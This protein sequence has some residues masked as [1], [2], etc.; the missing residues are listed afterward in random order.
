MH[1]T[2]PPEGTKRPALPFADQPYVLLILTMLFWAGNTLLGRA[3]AG[4]IPPVALAQM[5]WTLAFLILLP[6]ALPHL[7]RDLPDMLRSWKIL[8]ILGISGITLYNTFLYIG[9]QTTSAVNAAMLI[10][11]FPIIVALMGFA[12]F[13]D[14][15]TP[16]QVAGI[17][18]SC[19]GAVVILARGSL[20]TLRE[21]DFAVGDL[22]VVGCQIA[23]ALYAVLL[24]KRPAIHPLSFVTVTIFIGQLV[25]IPATLAEGAG[26]ERVT[27][28]LATVA[29]VLYVAIFPAILSYLFF[30]RAVE[31][32]GSNRAAP[33][34]HL[35]PLFTSL[36]AVTLLGERIAAYHVMGFLLILAG[37]IATQMFRAR[38]PARA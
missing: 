10:S 8:T 33:F 22:W 12:F 3:M 37:I 15:L 13:R 18:V 34:F 30:N 23:Y 9:V 16:L 26:G 21:V 7:R 35:V 1:K 17:L 27:F 29:S 4:E 28:D 2:A 36:G 14:R 20:A 32:I 5:R 38:P 11:L 19:V 31:L 24:R 6:F 25:L